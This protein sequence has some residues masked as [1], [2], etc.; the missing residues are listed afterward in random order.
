MNFSDKT[1]VVVGGGTAGWLCALFAERFFPNIKVKLIES[2]NVDIIGVGESTTP[3]FVGLMNFLG[4]SIQDLIK[5]GGV[6]IKN[7]IKFTNWNGDGK[8]YFHG[9]PAAPDLNFS[10]KEFSNYYTEIPY[11]LACPKILMA[12]N[13]IFEGKNLDQIHFHSLTSEQNRV[14]F[15]LN[16]NTNNLKLS[17]PNDFYVTASYALHINARQVASYFKEVG[18]K[19]GVEL[20]NGHV[21][22]CDQDDQGYVTTIRLED[23]RNID[24]DFVFDCSGM[25][26]IFV[27]KVFN[28]ELKPYK[29]NLPVKQAIPFFIENTGPTPPYT[30]AISM[31]N[32]WMW[33]IPVQGRFGCGYVYDSDY[34]S[35]HE[36]LKEVTEFLGFEP[37][38][39]K[40][41]SFE[42]GYYK[43]TWNKNVLAVGLSSGFIEPLE[44]TSIWIST[45][46]LELFSTFISGFY[47]RD[48]AAIEEYNEKFLAFTDS[49]LSLVH[50]HY[51]NKRDDTLFWKEF[52]E[53]NEM[54]DRLK[55]LVKKFN[56]RLPNIFDRHL[57][58]AFTFDSW[59]I[60]GAGNSFFNKN[61]IE[62][63]YNDYNVKK[64]KL[65][66]YNFKNTLKVAMNNCLNHDDFIEL[67]KK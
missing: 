41:I 55:T 30:E 46:S 29:K 61:V 57:M 13:E 2:K 52:R 53:K 64:L 14:P 37:S 33:K 1:V 67:M 44:A 22:G 27:K 35:S 31:K 25:A 7:S 32:G 47:S 18:Q 48:E 24:C 17:T 45:T 9:F 15:K 11:Y 23:E 59:Y 38:V 12:I 3:G 58:N 34:I 49:V 62:K 60:V 19:R 4:I 20:I 43:Q 40:V 5:Y 50:F 54:P 21:V 42:S 36:A 66:I 6:T 28:A 56:H 39:P 10:E 63:E 16:P 51:L 65:E 8:H 26:R